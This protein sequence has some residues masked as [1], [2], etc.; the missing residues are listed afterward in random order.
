MRFLFFLLFSTSLFAI[1]DI[2]PVDFKESEDGFSG[3]LFGAYELK[4]GNTDKNELDVGGRIQ[5][6][7]DETI[8]WLQ[9]EMEKDKVRNVDTDDNAFLHLRHVHQLYNPFW[10]WEAFTQYK[11]DKFKNLSDRVLLGGGIR[12]KLLDTGDY[13]K[14]FI[15]LG[16]YDEEVKYTE[17][18]DTGVKDPNENNVR[19]N[20]YISYKTKFQNNLELSL[21]SYF[22][23]KVDDNKDYMAATTA[24]LIIHL[25][26]VFDLSYKIEFDYDS[27]PPTDVKKEDIDQRLSF[28][29]RFG[30]DDPFSTYAHT[31]L[32]S[33]AGLEDINTSAII[34]VE[35]ETDI[36]DIKDF[37]DTFAGIWTFGKE[38]FHIDLDG[39]GVYRYDKGIYTEKL[40]WKL[41]STDTQEGAQVAKDQ[42][43]K[44]VII[45]FEDEEGRPGRVENYLWSES[46]LVGLS[47]SAVRLF[48]RP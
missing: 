25:T 47:G 14:V 9:G 12:Y 37:R 33:T 20:S 31:F 43:T 21:L 39:K 3:S 34:A 40:S 18:S 48:K 26:K 38:V 22:Q 36:E 44:L 10:A 15:G 46:T 8:T 17:D 24:E 13:N 41:I 5:Y 42:S 6:D 7:T 32:T 4:R 2:A 30:K 45:R 28:I 11:T 23:P 27:D 19:I 35:V 1:V 29:Y 16:F